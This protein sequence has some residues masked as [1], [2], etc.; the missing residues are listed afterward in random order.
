MDADG[1]REQYTNE[2]MLY[3]EELELE[4]FAE[5]SPDKIG[6]DKAFLE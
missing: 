3:S 1:I 6:L 2:I 5:L 4:D